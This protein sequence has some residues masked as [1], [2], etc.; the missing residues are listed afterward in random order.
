M[1]LSLEHVPI[2]EALALFSGVTVGKCLYSGIGKFPSSVR[3]QEM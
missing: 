2:S 3:S 1:Q